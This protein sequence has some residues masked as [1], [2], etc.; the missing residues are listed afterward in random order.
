MKTHPFTFVRLTAICVGLACNA[1]GSDPDPSLFR[2]PA[3][4]GPPSREALLLAI[5][6]YSIPFRENVTLYLTQP[7][8]RRE[9]VLRPSNSPQAPDN[10]AVHLYGTVM[11]DGGRFRMWYYALGLTGAVE[12]EFTRSPLCYAESAD[13]IN[14]TRPNLGQVEWRGSR[15]NNL[16]ALGDDPKATSSGVFV[17]RDDEDPRTDR[18]Y[19]LVWYHGLVIRTAVSGDGLRWRVLPNNAYGDRTIEISA[20]YKH[21]GM[22]HMTGHPVLRGEGDRPEGRQGYVVVSSDFEHW[23]PGAASSFKT[24]EPL[25]GAGYGK[26]DGTGLYTQV[27]LGVGAVS[28]GNVLVGLYGMWHHRQPRWGE[29]GINTD[30][31][32]VVGH[33]G[34]HF[35]EV[36]K[37][38]PYLRSEDSPATPT[39]GRTYPTILCQSNSILQVGN[40][41][42]IYHGRWRNAEFEP[43]P[44]TVDDAVRYRSRNY[45]G[46]IAL[47]R[48]T[49]DRWGA[50]GLW[51]DKDSGSVWTTAVTLPANSRLLLNASGLDGLR[52]EVRD[53]RFQPTPG[54]FEGR[55]SGS[56]NDALDAE[57]TWGEK[58]LD[59]LAG[60]SVRFRVNF[61]RSESSNP[62]LFALKLERRPGGSADRR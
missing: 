14:W 10:K 17:I 24:P 19:K 22:Y 51:G 40:E 57:V 59:E 11:Q 34:I 6:E 60:R 39:P 16:I 42:W 1:S 8:V 13:G 47:A 46:E 15:D 23:I 33:D 61:T 44:K 30:L 38:L 54:F 50:L 41:T 55:G 12:N 21:G 28:M 36:V 5:D 20:L 45:W 26:E 37:D 58:R 18:R 32:L 31:G 49:R 48:I 27:H 53:E 9:P 2:L 52:V 29:T 3:T 56:R 35:H 43:T 25:R 4:G 62:R 7:D